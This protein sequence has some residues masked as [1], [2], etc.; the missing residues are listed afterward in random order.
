[1]CHRLRPAAGLADVAQHVGGG[2]DLGIGQPGEGGGAQL[3]GDIL[4]LPDR[5]AARRRQVDGADPAV[6]S[7][8][9][10]LDEAGGLQPVEQADDGGAVQRQRGGEVLLPHRRRRAGEVEQRQPGGL[11]QAEGLEPGIHGAP[12]L[13]GGTADEAAEGVAEVRPHGAVGMSDGTSLFDTA[14]IWPGCPSLETGAGAPGQP[15]RRS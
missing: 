8:L 9:P 10:P 11:G 7:L 12:P 1:M 14:S 13:P 2:L 3:A 6:R 15:H 5:G 4:H